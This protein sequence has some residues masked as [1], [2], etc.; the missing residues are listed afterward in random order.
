M[1]PGAEQVNLADCLS[2][3]ILSGHVESNIGMR[4]GTALYADRK[5]GAKRGG[6]TLKTPD[7][8]GLFHAAVWFTHLTVFR[9]YE[10]KLTG[11]TT[12]PDR[13]PTELP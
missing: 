6:T 1:G 7:A 2:A 3:G 8:H 12:P 9:P 13:G 4:T 11:A 5:R 10:R